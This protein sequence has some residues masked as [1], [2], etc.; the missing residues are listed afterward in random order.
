MKKTLL[1]N[2][3][4]INPC[5]D[6]AFIENAFVAISGETIESVDSSEPSGT[7]DEVF[8]LD[9]KVALPGMINAHHHLYSALAVGMPLPKGNPTNFTEILQE[10]WWKMDLALDRDST[11]ACF[12]S[13]LLDSLKA[14]TTTFIDHHCSPSF[15]EGSLSLLAETG[16]KFGLNSSVALKS[17]TVTVQ[18]NS[19]PVCRKILTLS[20][21]FLIIQM[22]IADW[23]ACF[24]YLVRRF[25]KKNPDSP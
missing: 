7:F 25:F 12:E 24:F 1:K 5:S 10:V 19:R 8:D 13:G 14:G 20:G 11:Q 3:H 18:K 21:N 16:E 17:P 4:V 23:F 22:S 6:P 9:G 15:I 2:L